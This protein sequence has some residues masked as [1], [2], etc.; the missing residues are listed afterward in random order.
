MCSTPS[1]AVTL[2]TVAGTDAYGAAGMTAFLTEASAAGINVMASVTISKG[3]TDFSTQIEAIKQGASQTGVSPRLIVIFAQVATG[4]QFIK[5]GLADGLINNETTLWGSDAM[6]KPALDNLANGG[7]QPSS[8]KGMFALT[9]S[10]GKGTAR[11]N[12]F[13]ELYARYA[14]DV[15]AAGNDNTVGTGT[16][17]HAQ[18]DTNSVGGS[19]FLWQASGDT[20]A[21]LKT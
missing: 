17:C 4:L 21:S 12:A 1:A 14:A 7:V 9:P 3:Q 11:F 15:A 18:T 20:K 6:K 16:A 13:T 8:I 19:N 5:A 10:S 2:V